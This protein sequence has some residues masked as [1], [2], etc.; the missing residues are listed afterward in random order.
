MNLFSPSEIVANYAAAGA[1]KAQAPAW[2]L[3]LLGILAGFCISIGGVV[4]NT[5]SHCADSAASIRLISG[6]LF[7]FGLAM[8]VLMGA[9]LFTGNCL[10]SISV[11]D[12][13]ASFLGMLRNWVLVYAGNF[14]GSALTAA[15][16]V[17]AGQLD[18]SS[19]GLAVFTIKLAAA[20][21]S[22]D[23]GPAF[24]LG[25]LC[26]LLVC[27]GVLLSL[28]AK[29]TA[30]RILGAYLPVAF[31]VLAGYEHCV[32]NMYYVP[33]GIF[34]ASIPAYAEKAAAL[35]LDLTALSWSS[36]IVKNLVPVTLGN[37]VGGAALGALLWACFRTKE[38]SGAAR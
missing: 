23:F 2:K 6:L 9:E 30:G 22:I 33:A 14:I 7:P 25:V 8:V 38:P 15:A 5:A 1:A 18:Y 28:S 20:K 32:A 4:T 3:L 19:C 16:G 21:C 35:G 24:V 13:K 37:I 36:F 31:F 10:I 29:D 26:N 34:A 11:L 17:Y 12:G 27:S